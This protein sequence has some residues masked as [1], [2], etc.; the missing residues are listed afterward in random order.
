MSLIH[1]TLIGHRAHDDG[2]GWSANA[3]YADWDATLIIRNSILWNPTATNPLPEIEAPYSTVSASHSIIRGGQHGGIDQAPGLA[4]GG[5]MTSLSPA[6]QAGAPGWSVLDIHGE[7]RPTNPAPDLGW[8]Q[9]QDSNSN[10]LPDWVET[11]GI[12]DPAADYDGD[13]L[14]NLVEFQ[15]H[16]TNLFA[17]DTDGDGFSDGDEVLVHGTNPLSGDT[18]GDG[19][20]DAYEVANGLNPLINDA[21]GDLDGDGLTNLQEYQA[22]T[23]PKNWDTDGDLLPDGWEVQYGL[24]PLDVTGD[25]GADSDP[26]GDGLSNFQEMIH[27]SNPGVADTDGDG[28]NDGDEV[29]QGSNPNDPGDGG[30]PPPADEM[31]D[32]PFS[33]GDPSGSHS[34]RWRMNIQA[35]GPEDTRQFGFVSP[36]FGE[37]GTQTFKL[38]RGNS[39]TITIS[40]VATNEENGPDYDWQAQV[41]SKPTTTVL[42]G[43][44]THSGANRVAVI[45]EAWVL[46]NEQGLLGVVNQSFH[47]TNHAAGKVANLLPVDIKEVASDQINDSDCNKLP[48]AKYSGEPNNPMLMATR[49]GVRAHLAIKVDSPE[50]FRDKIFVGARKVG[51]TT[52]LGS[53]T[54]KAPNEKTK[55]EFDALPGHEIYEVVAGYD[56]NGNSALDNDEAQIVFKKT[57]AGSATSGLQ[58][59]DKIIIVTESQ[60]G[61]SKGTVAGYN[62]WGTGYAGDLIEGFA[63]GSATISGATTANNVDISAN[64]PGLSHPVGGRWNPDCKDKTYRFTFADASSASNDFEGSNAFGQI[65]DKVARDNLAALIAAYD[66]TVEWA[67]SPP[68]TFNES[69]NL[70]ETESVFIGFNKL[71]LAFGKVD[72]GGTIRFSYK[73]TGPNTI[74]VGSVEVLGSFN[75][76]Y[77]FAYGG[78]DQARQAS[79]VQAGH[80]TL[81]KAP[82]ANAGKVFFTRLEFNSGWKNWNRN[83]TNP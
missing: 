44:A 34:E 62:V 22:G 71:G 9:F 54:V 59:L 56:Q 37:M 80:A 43:G 65:V 52:I 67:V 58:Y 11:L 42:A 55:L 39:Y 70:I 32:V 35:N 24:N 1:C 61:A 12:T 45:K 46:D 77:D 8:D 76:L 31:V 10:G 51:A 13:G 69:K 72:I 60:F 64:E 49:T 48:T 17:A 66:G 28:V 15:T 3:I 73:K 74:T 6:R 29:N 20:P 36:N 50:G 78:G 83:Y 63:K 18:D 40:H 47:G 57:P 81:A 26:D 23:D 53:V 75:D 79:M 5:W 16:G 4:Y 33:V 30:Q 14:S 27:G 38:R 7:T 82:D 2:Y 21:D 19:M 25:N 68:Y 41:D